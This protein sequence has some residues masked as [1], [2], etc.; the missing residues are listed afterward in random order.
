VSQPPEYP[1]RQRFKRVAAAA[2]S[3]AYQGAFEAIGSVLI[4]GAFGYWVDS[5]WDTR[6]FGL[7]IGVGIGFAAMVLRLIRL[8]KELHPD[9]VGTESSKSDEAA[10]PVANDLGVGEAPGLSSVLRDDTDVG[11]VSGPGDFSDDDESGRAE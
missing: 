6:P 9:S 5:R 1:G 2:G 11:D 3:E 7:L 10:A 8:G 4:A